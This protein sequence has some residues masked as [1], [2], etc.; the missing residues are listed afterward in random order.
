M[1]ENYF[2]GDS[3][4]Y[5]GR[6]I[7]TFGPPCLEGVYKQ[8]FLTRE[9]KGAASMIG[10]IN[11]SFAMKVEGYME[12][13]D[14]YF[15]V[16]PSVTQGCYWAVTVRPVAETNKDVM[17]IL[18]NGEIDG[19]TKGITWNLNLSPTKFN[20]RDIS[21]ELVRVNEA[22]NMMAFPDRYNQPEEKEGKFRLR[23]SIDKG[24]VTMEQAKEIYSL[25]TTTGKD[26]IL[27]SIPKKNQEEKQLFSY[28]CKMTNINFGSLL[29][30]IAT[31]E[32]NKTLVN[33]EKLSDEQEIIQLTSL[34]KI[35]LSKQHS[36]N[37]LEPSSS[38]SEDVSELFETEEEKAPYW[39]DFKAIHS[40]NV[41]PRTENIYSETGRRE[42]TRQLLDTI[43]TPR[44]Q[45][46][47]PK[48]IFAKEATP[49][50]LQNRNPVIIIKEDELNNN[51]NICILRYGKRR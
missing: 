18:E 30:K 23:K 12:E 28:N 7:Y 11:R 42:T 2:G 3:S 43:A 5:F 29:L 46:L 8:A 38:S 24:R 10:T 16:F 9:E 37:Q 21:E 13:I 4:Q 26:I 51:N 1:L 22:F 20:V 25:Y 39:I 45:K 40:Q 41:S 50:L 34:Q 36:A 32:R 49:P 35:P 48:L 14:A 33:K 6:H 31:L 27:A 47:L 17:Y 19:G 15:D 44:D